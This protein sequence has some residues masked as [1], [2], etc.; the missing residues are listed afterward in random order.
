MATTPSLDSIH[1]NIFTE[2]S[3]EESDDTTNE[4]DDGIPESLVS[5][6]NSQCHDKQLITH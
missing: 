1:T 4:H 6:L 5:D 3:S 2:I